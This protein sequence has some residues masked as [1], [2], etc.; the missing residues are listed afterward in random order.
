MKTRLPSFVAILVALSLLLVAFYTDVGQL[1]AQDDLC[2]LP[3]EPVSLP[4]TDL[5]AAEY[6]RLESG[7]TGFIGG[8]YPN[9]QNDRPPTHEAVGLTQARQIKPRNATGQPDPE[10]LIGLLSIG[11]SNTFMEFRAF[12]D[13]AAADSDLNP[14]LAIVNGAQAGQVAQDWADPNSGAWEFLLARLNHRRVTPQQVQ[15]VWLKQVN[16]GPGD[17]PEKAQT[18]QGDL[19]AI[20]QTVKSVFPNVQIV[21]LSSRTRSY[22]YW[23]GLS[24]E[25]AA[26][27]SGFAV[28]WLIEQQIAGDPALNFAGPG[29]TAVV[30]YLT[31]GPYLWADG[32]TPRADGFT[33]LAS[34]LRRDCT[35]P[36]P[37]GVAKIADVLLTFFK[38]DTTS[39]PWFLNNPPA[40]GDDASARR[41][42]LRALWQNHSL[43][44]ARRSSN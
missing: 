23:N 5:G 13:L 8:L 17:F 4:L 14:R 19:M 11:M 33:W 37:A 39:A 3:F 20:V 35:H 2:T 26:F 24:P 9:G 22:T 7:S 25:P 44:E 36:S 21:Y 38:T 1:A 6:V 18:L 42:T 32:Q 12:E 41:A 28:K 31:W 27:E 40:A 10:G 16:T 30:P 34:D 15:V 43:N 29:E